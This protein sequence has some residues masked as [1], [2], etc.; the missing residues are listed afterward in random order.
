VTENFLRLTTDVAP[1]YDQP[2]PDKILSG[3]PEF[4][5]WNVEDRDG[6]LKG[7]IDTAAELGFDGKALVA[8]AEL[9]E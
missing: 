3:A 2:A 9:I 5:T 6:L 8:Q 7:W 1:E 4:T